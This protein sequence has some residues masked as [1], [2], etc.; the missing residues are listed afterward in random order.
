MVLDG[1]LLEGLLD[2]GVLRIVLE[3]EQ[4]VVALPGLRHGETE[5]QRK[6]FQNRSH[7]RR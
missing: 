5:G 1:Q 6:H 7:A 2:L 3:A 4:L